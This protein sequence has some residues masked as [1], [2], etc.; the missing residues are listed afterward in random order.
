MTTLSQSAIPSLLKV[1]RSPLD[2]HLTSPIGG[3]EACKLIHWK[4]NSNLTLY[5]HFRLP[6]RLPIHSLKL[7]TSRRGR[8]P[9]KGA[10]KPPPQQHQYNSSEACKRLILKPAGTPFESLICTRPT[11][12]AVDICRLQYPR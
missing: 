10:L 6:N 11:H 3:V 5:P 2:S 8:R 12:G 9:P 4:D 1:K 7:Q